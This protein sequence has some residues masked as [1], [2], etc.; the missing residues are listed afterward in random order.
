MDLTST[1]RRESRA[2]GLALDPRPCRRT[3][4]IDFQADPTTAHG[5]WEDHGGSQL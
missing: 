4:S 5:F 2:M 1:L 3:T